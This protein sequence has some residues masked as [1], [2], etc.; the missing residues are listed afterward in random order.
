MTT[1]RD[2][3]A[4]ILHGKGAYCGSCGYEDGQCSDCTEV[5][6]GYAE[7][8]LA[9]GYRKHRTVTTPEELDALPANSAILDHEGA[10]WLSDGDQTEPWASVCENPLGG[11]IWKDSGDITLPATVLYEGDR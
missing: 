5:L 9:A 10:P 8:I 6:A 3:L 4:N 2:E 1:E 7:A 11:P